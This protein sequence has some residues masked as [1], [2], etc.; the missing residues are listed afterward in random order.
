MPVRSLGGGCVTGL[1]CHTLVPRPVRGLVDAGAFAGILHAPLLPACGPGLRTATSLV[2][3]VRSLGVTVRGLDECTRVH[4]VV[5]RLVVTVHGHTRL[6]VTVH[7]HT[8]PATG[9]VTLAG[10]RTSWRSHWDRAEAVVASRDRGNSGSGWSQFHPPA[11]ALFA[12]SH[13]AVPQP[14]RDPCTAGCRYGVYVFLAAGITGA[15][16]CCSGV[17]R[18]PLCLFVCECAGFGCGFSCWCCLCNWLGR[19]T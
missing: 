5:T 17:I 9:R 19:S 12:G 13:Q 15:W 3:F 11:H 16:P 1:A 2:E 10:H 14:V 18:S 7:G 8:G 4:L 6:G